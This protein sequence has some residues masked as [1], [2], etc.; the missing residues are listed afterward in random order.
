MTSTAWRQK[1]E[2]IVKAALPAVTVSAADEKTFSFALGLRMVVVSLM[3]DT[4]LLAPSFAAGGTIA[5]RLESRVQHL[6]VSPYSFDED[7]AE[8]AAE[9][10]VSHHR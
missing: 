1:V 4:A 5:S 3:K 2:M 9:A 6:D 8:A 10:I 7:A